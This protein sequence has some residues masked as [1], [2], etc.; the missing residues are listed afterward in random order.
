MKTILQPGSNCWRV[1]PVQRAGLLIDGRDYF[2]AF[3]EAA[4]RAQR[5][6][7]ITGWQFDRDA[8]LLVSEDTREKTGDVQFLPFLN[9][10][11]Q[12]NP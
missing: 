4:Q 8:T 11:C 1:E 6:I 9:G 5:Y 3:H 12:K 7:L 10:L 2:L